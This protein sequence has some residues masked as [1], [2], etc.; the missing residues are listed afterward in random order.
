LQRGDLVVVEEQDLGLPAEVRVD[1]L[2][3]RLALPVADLVLRG[4]VVGARTLPMTQTPLPM[5]STRTARCASGSIGLVA[6]APTPRCRNPC[7]CETF[8]ATFPSAEAVVNFRPTSALAAF[9]ASVHRS[10]KAMFA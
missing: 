2:R 8:V 6:R 1:V 7:I 3:G 9:I 4:D 10:K 5:A